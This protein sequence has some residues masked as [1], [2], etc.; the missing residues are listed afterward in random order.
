MVP[1]SVFMSG[2]RAK[3]FSPLSS[4]GVVH[5][6]P[7]SGVRRTDRESIY[8]AGLFLQRVSLGAVNFVG[9][10][11]GIFLVKSSPIASVM[12]VSLL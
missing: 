4:L 10:V 12:I 8:V 5:G 1:R 6:R 2:T 11:L 9:E 3:H 7:C